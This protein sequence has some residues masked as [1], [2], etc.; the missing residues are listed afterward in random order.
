MLSAR[1]NTRAHLNRLGRNRPEFAHWTAQPIL[2]HPNV[3]FRGSNR[4]LCDIGGDK[5]VIDNRMPIMPR[6]SHAMEA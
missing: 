5:D 2:P 1:P 6:S 3:H 4:A